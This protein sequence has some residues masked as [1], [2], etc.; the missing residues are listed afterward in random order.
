MH[1]PVNE[2]SWRVYFIGIEFTRLHQLFDFGHRDF[3]AGSC[4]RIEIA[5]GAAVDEIAVQIGL[6]CFHQRE[7]GL[8]AAFKDVSLASK[9]LCSLPSAMMVPIPV[10]V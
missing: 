3:A 1:E 8:N 9:S 7:V 10:R 2:D 6:P 5:R 4:V